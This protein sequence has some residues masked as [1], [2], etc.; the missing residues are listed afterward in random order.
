MYVSLIYK[1]KT[2]HYVYMLNYPVAST[3]GVKSQHQT[4]YSSFQLDAF[5]HIPTR[6]RLVCYLEGCQELH[7]HGQR[8]KA[9][10]DGS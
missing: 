7:Q 8:E 4:V 10:V 5:K 2:H 9:V 1:F 6:A 3:R